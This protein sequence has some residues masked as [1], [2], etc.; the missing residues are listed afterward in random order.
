M[1]RSFT[2]A[3]LGPLLG[4]AL[5][6]ASALVEAQAA[7]APAPAASIFRTAPRIADRDLAG[8]RGGTASAVVDVSG[9]LR[10]TSAVDVHSGTN[11]IADGSFANALGL[12]TVIQNSGSNVLIQNAT[13]V[14]VQFK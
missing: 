3:A 14:N 11:T 10:Q 12:T 6:V 8:S 1:N 13:T 2:L 4:T 9:S 5:M 7:E